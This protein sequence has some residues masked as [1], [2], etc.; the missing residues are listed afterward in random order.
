[1]ISEKELLLWIDEDSNLSEGAPVRMLLLRLAMSLKSS[2]NVNMTQ[3]IELAVSEFERGI[4]S[5]LLKRLK[6]KDLIVLQLDAPMGS[7]FDEAEFITG[8]NNKIQLT[9]RGHKEVASYKVSL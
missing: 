4:L 1:M 8:I 5:S 7:S 6:H 9:E 2:S 3:S